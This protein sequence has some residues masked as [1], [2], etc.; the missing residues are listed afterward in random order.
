MK[1][2]ALRPE[3]EELLLRAG[4]LH[5]WEHEILTPVLFVYY[6][7]AKAV[8]DVVRTGSMAE[9]AAIANVSRSSI[10]RANAVGAHPF[11]WFHERWTHR[12]EA[13][14]RLTKR[15]IEALAMTTASNERAAL[16]G[17]KAHVPASRKMEQM[18]RRKKVPLRDFLGTGAAERLPEAPVSGIFLSDGG[19][20]KARRRKTDGVSR[21]EKK[22]RSK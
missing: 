17:A 21:A 3:V 5:H 7:Y 4:H 10:F 22:S 19:L 8:H 20:P 16:A 12:S 9:A 13:G 6:C 2:A 15:D 11:E 14:E 18:T 1:S